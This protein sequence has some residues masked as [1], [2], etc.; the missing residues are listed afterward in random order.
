[1]RSRP[2]FKPV[3]TIP[4]NSVVHLVHFHAAA[5]FCEERNSQ[6]TTE[7]FPEIREPF[8]Y[9]R[10]SPRVALPQLVMPQVE[11]KPSK[12]IRDAVVFARGK[13][14]G[15][16]RIAGVERNADCHG[17]AMIGLIFRQLLELVLGPM[18]EIHW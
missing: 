16:D 13:T 2:L 15:Q 12:K 1:M 18:T 10:Q 4:D 3:N 5:D 11:T 9:H 8:Q 14:A 17:L 6:L 7:M